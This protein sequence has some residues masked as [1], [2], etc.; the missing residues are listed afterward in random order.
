MKITTGTI[1]RPNKKPIAFVV[2]AKPPVLSEAAQRKLE[3]RKPSKKA[4]KLMASVSK[5]AVAINY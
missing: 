1:R 2:G 3:R 5:A 4:V